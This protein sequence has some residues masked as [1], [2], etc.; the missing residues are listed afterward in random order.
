MIEPMSDSLTIQNVAGAI[1]YFWEAQETCIIAVD[2]SDCQNNP[3]G[4]SGLV[5]LQ[6]QQHGLLHITTG[7]PYPQIL[8]LFGYQNLS[9]YARLTLRNEI[10]SSV[11]AHNAA[12]N[13]YESVRQ[14]CWS[15]P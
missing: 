14:E 3:R 9:Q 11:Q 13:D 12:K 7:S 4:P 2:S 8:Y 10:N 6:Q 1:N 5:L 15:M